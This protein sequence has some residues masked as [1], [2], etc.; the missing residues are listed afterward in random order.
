MNSVTLG[1]G[2]DFRRAFL[3]N[4]ASSTGGV[5]TRFVLGLLLARLLQP[6]ELGLY[7]VAAAVFGVA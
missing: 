6:A 2:V 5:A 1:A 3:V 4:L 7:A